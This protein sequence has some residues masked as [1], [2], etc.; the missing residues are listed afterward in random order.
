MNHRLGLIAMLL[1]QIDRPLIVHEGD[2]IVRRCRLKDCAR[3]TSHNNGY[4][5]AKHCKLDRERRKKGGR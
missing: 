1:A 5:C 3:F 4:C 2:T